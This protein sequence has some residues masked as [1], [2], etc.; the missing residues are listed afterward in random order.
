[1]TFAAEAQILR[2]IG[3]FLMNGGLFRGSK[4]VLW[5]V[6][7]KTALAEA[8]VE[9]HDHVSNTIYVAFPVRTSA[10]PIFGGASAVIW[11]T[12]PW[13]IPGN[14][15]IAYGEAI[16]YV[17]LQVDA[18]A[19]GSKV[20][21]GAKLILAKELRAAFAEATGITAI[22]HPL[23]RARAAAL[24]GMV[25]HHPLAGRGYD[26]AVPLLPGGFVTTEQG[27]GLVHIAPGHG[28]DDWELA[29]RPRRRGAA[30]GG[31]RRPLFRSCAAVSPA[32]GC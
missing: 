28:A 24:A 20:A 2:E 32:S 17:L 18:V 15:A 3:K 25:C 6:V 22:Q 5:S 10:D 31:W 4:P 13:T 26:F 16:D 19:E 12:T 11:T 8:E 29:P 27:T 30:D 7:E 1:M 23:V 21:P 14:R 9:Y